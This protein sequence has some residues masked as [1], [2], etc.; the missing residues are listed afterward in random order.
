[1]LALVTFTRWRM[2]AISI[3]RRPIPPPTISGPEVCAGPC[4]PLGRLAP[5]SAGASDPGRPRRGGAA[6]PSAAI[7]FPCCGPRSRRRSDTGTIDPYRRVLHRLAAALQQRAQA[8]GSRCQEDVVH[9]GVVRAADRL[10]RI[11]VAPDQR[12]A[13][14]R[15]QP[16]D[17][18][19]LR[20]PAL[21]RGV[22]GRRATQ[23]APGAAPFAAATARTARRP[24]GRRRRSRLSARS[25]PAD[26]QGAGS[27]TG[28]AAGGA[29]GAGSRNATIVVIAAIPSAMV[30]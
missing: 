16:S 29:S 25:G 28:A 11:E 18:G 3:S 30:W 9:R 2:T 22:L 27:Q 4:L 23:R 7:R 24:I 14:G 13:V 8:A 1:M 21:R 15:A 5:R 10:D 17:R 6:R 20:S 12:Q 19:W 26:G